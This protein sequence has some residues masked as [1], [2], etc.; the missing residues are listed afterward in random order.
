MVIFLIYFCLW[1]SRVGVTDCKYIDLYMFVCHSVC[2]FPKG[3]GLIDC[4]QWNEDVIVWVCEG[5][6]LWNHKTLSVYGTIFILI[7]IEKG[8]SQQF[9]SFL[10][11]VIMRYI[12]TWDSCYKPCDVL[13]RKQNHRSLSQNKTV[14]DPS[15]Q[16]HDFLSTRQ[17]VPQSCLPWHFL[18]R[19]FFPSLEI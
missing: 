12:L 4:T 6:W 16:S 7:L 8:T 13:F 19:F 5:W 15:Q 11:R 18:F 10:Q 14:V 9:P 3:D 2:R 17:E 1:L